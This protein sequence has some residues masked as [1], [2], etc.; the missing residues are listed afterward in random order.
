MSVRNEQT[1]F[2]FDLG[3]G[4]GEGD[5]AMEKMLS[6]EVMMGDRSGDSTTTGIDVSRDFFVST[7]LAG[8]RMSGEGSI[9]SIVGFSTTLG[10]VVHRLFTSNVGSAFSNSSTSSESSRN[11]FTRG[12]SNFFGD[13]FLSIFSSILGNLTFPKMLSISLLSDSGSGDFSLSSSS[14][15]G[16]SFSTFAVMIGGVV[17]PF[18]SST[19]FASSRLS[20]FFSSTFATGDFSLT[21]VDLSFAGDGLSLSRDDFVG[22]FT[23]SDFLSCFCC[24]LSTLRLLRLLMRDF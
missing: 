12:F 9:L 14:N 8:T 23:L 16:T 19:S 24:F 6:I 20:V 15:V 10:G 1:F 7:T 11:M 18:S 21:C 13:F 4:G 2:T 22:D 5:F 17:E 3:F